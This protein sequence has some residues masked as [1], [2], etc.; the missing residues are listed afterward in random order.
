MVPVYCIG[1][2]S[3]DTLGGALADFADASRGANRRSKISAFNC[4]F[5]PLT[6]SEAVRT[7]LT[8][9]RESAV[10]RYVV[11]PNVHHLVLLQKPSSLRRSY[12]NA[13]L[14]LVDGRPVT[15]ALKLLHEPVPE[16]VPG[17]DLVPAL[18]DAATRD[19]PLSVFLLGAAPGVA[20][21]AKDVIHRRWP[22]V[23][24]VG[25][26]GPPQSFETD[27]AE[28]KHILDIVREAS[29][30][31]LVIGLGCPKQELWI[32][33]FAG[34]VDARVAICAGA[35][36]DFIAGHRQ[37]APLWVQKIGCEWLFRALQEPRRMGRRYL[38]DVWAFPAMIV[39]EMLRRRRASKEHEPRAQHDDLVDV[40]SRDAPAS[41]TF[42]A[43]ADQDA[44]ASA[45]GA[46][47]ESVR[48]ARQP[49]S[50]VQLAAVATTDR[51][52]TTWLNGRLFQARRKSNHGQEKR[53]VL[54][55]GHEGY[56]GSILAPLLSNV[57]YEVVGLDSRLFAD[58]TFA[59]ETMS[60]PSIDKDVRD[61]TTADLE[62]FDAVVHLAAVA[63]ALGSLEPELTYDINLKGSV[64]LAEQA[65]AAGVPRFIFSSSSSIFGA[66]GDLRLA[67][68]AA[69]N[70]VTPHGV[71]KMWAERDIGRLADDSFCPTFLRTGVAYGL[72][73]RM[74]FDLVL[75]EFV[76]AALTTG[77]I[78]IE[79]NGSQW[80]PLVHVQDIARAFAAI[81]RAPTE[82]VCNEVFNVGH[83]DENYRVRD[84][85]KLVTDVVP[86][87]RVEYCSG[88]VAEAQYSPLDCR[89]IARLS[90]FRPEWTVRR[91]VVELYE[92]YRRAG[93]KAEDFR[94]DRFRRAQYI[95]N[96]IA[97]GQLDR[98]LRRKDHSSEKLLTA[99]G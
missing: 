89:K 52:P 57:G 36:I 47:P 37:R 83:S 40:P 84:V 16:V 63:G 67:E 23:R 58:C 64:R 75:N 66:A 99:A 79:G 98:D 15:W 81:L 88:A 96:L 74:R 8:W 5:D 41:R 61:V 6:K 86:M 50:C 70:P 34:Q 28:T 33:R 60:L 42:G 82:D 30:D 97:S 17:S 80:R 72:A 51:Q 10:C 56:I 27:E 43:L 19:N 53:R 21:R 87:S 13:S 2:T 25:A 73:P 22:H 20:E 92:A 94:G 62:G 85:A 76:A 69:S 68:T 48:E 11:T 49:S 26:Y 35:T 54:V 18:F 44:S 3:R 38:R 9:M 1:S 71:A 95:Q 24:I 77:R 12:R 45:A 65:K 78:A 46:K 31:L 7:I 93:L 4:E 90:E 29:P 59:G 14:T 91:G 55:T 32:C 39:R